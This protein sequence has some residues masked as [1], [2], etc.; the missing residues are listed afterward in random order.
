MSSKPIF[1]MLVAYSENRAIGR[2]NKLLWHLADD[3]AFFKKMTSGKT[4]IM[5]KNTYLSLPPKFRP[6]PNRKNIVIS[7]KSTE[8]IHEDL[9]WV[10]NIETAFQKALEFEESETY[11]IGGAQVYSQMLDQ[12]DIIYATEVKVIIAGDVYFPELNPVE[13]KKELIDSFS[14]NDKNDYDFN[15]VKYSKIRS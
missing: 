13:W 8:E 12:M 10:K 7:S 15:I 11:I 2:D 5:G 6:L 4:V 9:Y 14:K 3:M 1:S